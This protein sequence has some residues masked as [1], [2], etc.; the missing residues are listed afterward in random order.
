MLTTSDWYRFVISSQITEAPDQNF[1]YS[2]GHSSLMSPILK[3]RTDTDVYEFAVT[4]LFQPLD[5]SD[6]HWELINGGGTQ[7]QGIRTFPFGLEPLGYG[8]WLKPIDMA[9]IGELYLKNGIWQGNRLLSEDWINAS[10]QQYSN[11]QS[12]P[13]VF[14]TS[15][16]GYGYQWWIT[17]VTDTSNRS[18][19]MF[20]ASGYGGQFIFIIP[21]YEAVI[22]TTADD[23]FYEGPNIGT[24]L[25]ENLLLAFNGTGSSTVPLTTDYNGSW[26][27]PEHNGQGINFEVIN[28]GNNIAGFWYTYESDSGKQRWFSLQGD[29]IEGIAK[30]TIYSTSGGVF[31]GSQPAEI[32]EWGQGTLEVFNCQN[33]HFTFSS[34]QNINES[35]SG[36]F[37]LSRITASTGSCINNNKTNPSL[38]Y[39][40]R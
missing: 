13:D 31:V 30:F 4:E 33:G 2:T 18:A 5:I 7:G 32:V 21:Q 34:E 14:A 23:Y 19:D 26:Y 10:I 36:E 20:Y 40:L 22:V 6:T 38:G 28:Q 17:R 25:R 37:P 24:V 3:N 39:N 35:V 1:T 11:N 15:F 8:L 29:I 16:Q 9:K 27:F 12:D